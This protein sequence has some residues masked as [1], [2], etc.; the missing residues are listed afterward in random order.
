MGSRGVRSC[1]L[2]EIAWFLA[3]ADCV[4][5]FSRFFRNFYAIFLNLHVYKN[6]WQNVFF[7][8]YI[9]FR[10]KLLFYCCFHVLIKIINIKMS[11]NP[12]NWW[13]YFNRINKS[14]ANCKVPE[15]NYVKDTGKISVT[16]HFL[17][18]RLH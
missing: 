4:C 15:C 7:I 17:N 18:E 10:N 16:A 12:G 9:K 2:R 14:T 1:G 3:V 5:G 8:I 6:V 11:L 13:Y